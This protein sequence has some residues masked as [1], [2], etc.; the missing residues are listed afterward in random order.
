MHGPI[1]ID[2]PDRRIA[3]PVGPGHPASRLLELTGNTLKLFADGTVSVEG[4]L[5]LELTAS[6]GSI[7]PDPIALRLL[8]LRLPTV[9]PIPLGLLTDATGYLSNRAIHLKVLGTVHQPV[10]Q[11]EPLRL[12]SQEGAYYFLS[13]AIP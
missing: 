5:G 12:L 1:V 11:V 3:G 7:G 10:I 9:G 6:V 2:L 8:R 4:R 13:R